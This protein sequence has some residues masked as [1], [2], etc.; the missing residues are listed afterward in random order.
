MRSDVAKVGNKITF[1]AESWNRVLQHARSQVVPP[2][3]FRKA[4][5]KDGVLDFGVEY[6]KPVFERLETGIKMQLGATVDDRRSKNVVQGI[7]QLFEAG[8]GAVA[9]AI[10]QTKG[11]R[12]IDL[13]VHYDIDPDGREYAGF[14]TIN[15]EYT[16]PSNFLPEDFK[17]VIRFPLM[18]VN[19]YEP[20]TSEDSDGLWRYAYYNYTN[21]EHLNFIQLH[22]TI[23]SGIGTVNVIAAPTTSYR[24]ADTPWQGC[25]S[26][27]VYYAN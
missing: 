10:F 19:V 5:G 1:S 18:V 24:G 22:P 20:S 26:Q 11:P 14:L 25:R 9:G 2:Q 21:F 15:T 27:G 6:Y 4:S 7:P 13:N 12:F 23:L 8:F 16:N 3:S 17:L